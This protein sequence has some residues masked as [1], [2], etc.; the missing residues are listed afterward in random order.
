[1]SEPIATET[2]LHVLKRGST[3]PGELLAFD[4]VETQLRERL[5][6]EGALK[7]RE[8]ALEKIAEEY[9]VTAPTDELPGWRETLAAEAPAATQ[10]EA[11]KAE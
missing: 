2:G 11:A 7:L 6:Q 9:P 5:L 1:M 8:A 3:V 4:K 10:Q